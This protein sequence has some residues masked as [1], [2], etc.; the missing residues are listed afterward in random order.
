[1]VENVV[2]APKTAPVR[3]SG[4]RVIWNKAARGLI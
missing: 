1:M 2:E 3:I 4:K